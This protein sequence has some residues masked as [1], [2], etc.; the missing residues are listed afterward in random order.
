MNGLLILVRIQACRVKCPDCG[1]KGTGVINT[2][3]TDTE[4]R[5]Y[6]RCVCGFRFVTVEVYLDTFKKLREENSE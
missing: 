4:R 3:N 5:R 2:R 6:R 1:R